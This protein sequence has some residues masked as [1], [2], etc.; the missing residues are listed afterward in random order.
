MEKPNLI[1]VVGPTASGK[2][3]LAVF[4]A[5]KLGGEVISADSRQVYKG[6]DIGTGKITPEE[7]EGVAHHLLDVAE[8]KDQYTVTDF[9]RDAER[10]ISEIW[11]R[12]NIP[13]ICGGT[14][15]YIDTLLFNLT[16][17]EV[18]PNAALRR[19]LESKTTSE[20]FKLLQ[21]KDPERAETIDPHNPRRLVRA[22]EII[23][24]IGKVPPASSGDS[25]YKPLWIGL[26]PPKEELRGKIHKRLETRLA[27]GMLEE[28]K[29]LHKEGLSYERMEELG[30]EYRYLARHLQ[31]GLSYEEMGKELENA[32]CDYASR[33]LTWFK[34]NKA[35]HWVKSP[36]EALNI[37]KK[38]GL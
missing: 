34:R 14:G 7:M 9:K 8:P 3:T 16:I 35:I 32:I 23:E 11:G 27:S 13:L 31:G 38:A 20:L 22:L 24:A 25:P 15:L 5:K 26:N 10:A 19:E 4:L 28:A 6:L 12:N 2:S 30:L 33:Q 37:A 21:E 1:A 17:P 29:R 18:P 36:E